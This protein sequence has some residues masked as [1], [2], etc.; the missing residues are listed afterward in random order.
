MISET[1]LKNVQ[2]LS[3][4]NNMLKVIPVK[5]HFRGLG[6]YGCS[7]QLYSGIYWYIFCT[8]QIILRLIVAGL[9]LKQ[10]L[11]DS[12]IMAIDVIL[13]IAS[14]AVLIVSV[15]LLIFFTFQNEDSCQFINMFLRIN[16]H[17]C[18]YI[19]NLCK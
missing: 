2:I 5:M 1:S 17:L 10:L 3:E 19:N 12:R 15:H 18:K 14:I 6:I 11:L 13:G 8:F 16:Q 7:T 9:V 4:I